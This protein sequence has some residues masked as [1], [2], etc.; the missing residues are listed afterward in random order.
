MYNSTGRMGS[1]PILI[2]LVMSVSLFTAN[3]P[4]YGQEEIGGWQTYVDPAGRFT[5]Y[6]PP[7]LQAQGKENFLSS[8]DLT[9]GNPDFPREF[10]ITVT[11]NDDDTSLSQYIENLETSPKN[12]LLGVEKELKSSYQ[13]YNLVSDTLDSDELYGFPT[14]SNTV[15]YTDHLG[16]SGRM[17]NTLA[18]INGKGSFMFSYSNSIDRFDGYL[19]TVNQ[20][21]ESVVILK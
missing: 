1:T 18:I 14:V 6:Y 2:F 21:L 12:Y 5:L 7:D 8:T 19:P 4:A 17:M 10:K 13:N 20:I 11:Y 9:L 15:D 3:I 16:E